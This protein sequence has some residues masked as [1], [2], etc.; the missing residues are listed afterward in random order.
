M[1]A[2]D[3]TKWL[4]NART[5]SRLCYH[6]GHLAQER[7]QFSPIAFTYRTVPAIDEKARLVW[8]AYCEGK[9]TLTQERTGNGAFRYWAEKRRKPW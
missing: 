1:L 4:K 2:A 7:E 3:I 5:G 6:T 8:N 9:V